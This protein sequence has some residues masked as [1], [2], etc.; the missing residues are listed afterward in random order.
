[1]KSQKDDVQLFNLWAKT[2][3]IYIITLCS[4]LRKYMKVNS[5]RN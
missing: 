1:M 5:L 4:E 3:L 2:L